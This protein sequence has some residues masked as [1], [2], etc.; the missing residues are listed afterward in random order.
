MAPKSSPFRSALAILAT[1]VFAIAIAFVALEGGLRALGWVTLRVRGGNDTPDRTAYRILYLGESTTFGLG[2]NPEEAY[3]VVATALLA[4]RHPDRRF[5]GFNRGVPGM[6]T[7]AMLI[8]LPE[9]L[10]T[11]APN[12]VV[13]LAGANDFNEELNHIESAESWW[14]PA[15]LVPFVRELRLY[16][17][18]RLALELMRP[19]VGRQNFLQHGEV[20]YYRHGT[21]GN[22]LYDPPRDE[23]KIA[24]VT[25]QLEANLTT[26]IERSRQGGAEVVVLGYTRSAAESDIAERVAVRTG[27]LW[28]PMLLS[29]EEQTPDLFTADGWHPSAKGHRLIAEKLVPALETLLD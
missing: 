27:A 18:V 13:I 1:I 20:V 17:T 24:R 11:L 9:K 8:T 2:V 28:V 10:D 21:S 6:V 25:A 5:Q 29:Q 19:D 26:M 4:E 3:P 16:K 7:N 12:A 23:A 22:I 15:A 14:I